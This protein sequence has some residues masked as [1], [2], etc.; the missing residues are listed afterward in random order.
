M[1]RIRWAR[2]FALACVVASSA[3]VFAQAPFTEE[4]VIRG[5][6]YS[7]P[8]SAGPA[9]FGA[10][11]AFADLDGDL[12]ADVV[13]VGA[14]NGQIR[15][16][17]NDGTGYFVSRGAAGTPTPFASG[18]AAADY[19]GDGDL[20]LYISNWLGANLLLRN[21]G[22]F[23]FT[24][25]AGPAGVADVGP[26]AGCAWGDYDGDGWLDLYMVNR[27]GQFGGPGAANYPNR[28]YRNLGN[29][30]FVDEA[31]AQQ[32]DDAHFGFQGV[33]FDYDRDG[34]V[35]LYLSNDHGGSVGNRLWRN[36]AGA[37]VEVSAGSGA[38]VHIN[39]MGVAVGDFDR[40]GFLDLYVTNT[41]QGNPLLK[42]NANGTFSNVAAVLGVAA[43]WTGWGTH[44]VDVDNDARLELFV[45]NWYGR[46]FLYRQSTTPPWIE[47]GVPMGFTATG[48]T[49][50][51]ALADVDGDG[52]LDLLEQNFVS[53][54]KLFINNAASGP[55]WARVRLV[56]SSPNHHA[57]GA[58]IDLAAGGVVQTQH[59][60]AGV[61]FMGSSELIQHFG[62]ATATVIDSV[63]VTWP[64]GDQ[65]S[66]VN[67]PVNQLLT[68][69]RLPA[70]SDC[71]GNGVPDAQDLLS[72]VSADLDGDDIPDEC[73]ASLRR[74]DASGDGALGVVDAVLLLEAI[75]GGRR[76]LCRDAL[77]VNDDGGVNLVDPI[78]LL[79]YLF[80]S[81]AAPA[82]PFGACGL[83]L[84]ADA[85][86][87]NP[88]RS[89]CP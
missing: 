11:V 62:L 9:Q 42:N 53:P 19:D 60:Q 24:D 32:V 10:G 5:L 15:L 18:I 84:T 63:T 54:T 49:L 46:N 73:N 75:F 76:H 26:G 30:T 57:I 40:N 29:G 20:D 50:C 70:I 45:G 78:V 61:G 87:C 77:D 22:S 35:D 12:D 89:G 16:F 83:D 48:G 81:G 65:N 2:P 39:S 86:D 1:A 4:A 72:G 58:T 79:A 64:G 34:D 21:D 23:H 68:L 88:S 38:D 13:L 80:A 7:T 66:W 41:P 47:D 37:F 31:A 55:R 43:Y 82:A 33:F 25:V 14:A 27:T 6:N 8:S 67:L 44:F 17:E 36:D 74:G 69:E 85:L 3:A 71:N 52:D 51:T 28:L 59:V 56:G